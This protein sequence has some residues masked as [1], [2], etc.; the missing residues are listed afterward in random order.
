MSAIQHISAELCSPFAAPPAC[1]ENGNRKQSA[2]AH[3]APPPPSTKMPLGLVISGPKPEG[4]IAIEF[5]GNPR[6]PMM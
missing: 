1:Y 3:I 5:Q 2:A 6:S 4:N